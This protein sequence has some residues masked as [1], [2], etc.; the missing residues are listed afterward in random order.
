MKFF[1]IHNTIKFRYVSRCGTMY[2]DESLIGVI[3]HHCEYLPDPV[4]GERGQS[5]GFLVE[6]RVRIHIV[7]S[8]GFGGAHVKAHQVDGIHTVR[9]GYGTGYGPRTESKV[10]FWH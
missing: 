4:A 3:S 8:A 7:E 5:F 10:F 9:S 1:Q 2:P 6:F